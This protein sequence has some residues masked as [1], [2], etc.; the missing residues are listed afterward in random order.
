MFKKRNNANKKI[1]LQ[2]EATTI[3]AA[4]N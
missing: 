3:E 4:N 2:E 1:D